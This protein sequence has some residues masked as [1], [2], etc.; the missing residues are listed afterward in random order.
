[1]ARILLILDD[2]DHTLFKQTVGAGNV[3]ASLR[4]YIKSVIT[5][6]EKEE[7]DGL[8]RRKLNIL[9]KRKE[10]LD[11]EYNELKTKLEAIDEKR[12]I[13][14]LKHIEKLEKE[15]K[16]VS[17]IKHKHLKNKLRDV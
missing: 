17:E 16:K 13:E 7:K 11:T 8:S 6:T 12:E 10:R 3:S 1:M 9:Q 4:N 5:T 15:K 14:R 2:Y